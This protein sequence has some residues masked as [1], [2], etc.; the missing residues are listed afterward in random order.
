ML[1]GLVVI[2][3]AMLSADTTFFSALLALAALLVPIFYGRA[4][5]GRTNR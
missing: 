3:W 5:A 1:A 2:A 4:R